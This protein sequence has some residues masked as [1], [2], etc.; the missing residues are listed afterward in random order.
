[1]EFAY[2]NDYQASLKMDPFETLYGRKCNTPGNWENLAHKA[3]VGPYLLREMEEQMTKIKQ[4]LKVVHDRQKSYAYKN[5]V[6]IYF[7]VGKHVFLKVKA[8][9]SP[10]RLGSCLKL[11]LRYCGRFEILEKIKSV[12]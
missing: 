4:N 6:F 5:I 9:R 1:V 2:N 8:K 3:V 12:S 11:A 10:L 7:K